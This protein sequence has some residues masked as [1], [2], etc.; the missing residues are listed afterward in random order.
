MPSKPT[1]QKSAETRS[2]PPA[3]VDHE[4]FDRI[5]R[6]TVKDG[7]VDYEGLRDRHRE[8]LRSYLDALARAA[9]ES[10]PRNERLALYINLYNATMLAAIVER[11]ETG[12][13]TA[14][15][16]YRVFK[17]QLVRVA[18]QKVSL[19]HLENEIIRKGFKEPRI[20]V[21]LVCGA[22]SCP[23]LLARAYRAK[24]LAEVLEA[25][26]RRFVNDSTRNQ[27]DAAEKTLRLSEIFKWYKDDFGGEGGIVSYVQKYLDTDV[28]GFAVEHLPYSWELNARPR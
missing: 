15:E 3:T 6:D 25:N 7:A 17:A 19:N 22:E 1:T 2:A 23:P 4:P 27:V 26:M 18:G 10:L 24:D 13:S 14:A 20:H 12:Y 8:S 28:T 16:D 9:V 21:A 11:L 5:L